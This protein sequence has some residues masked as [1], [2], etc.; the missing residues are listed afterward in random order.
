MR[1][2]FFVWSG[3]RTGNLRK[4]RWSQPGKIKSEGK[5]KDSTED[6][7]NKQEARARTLCKVQYSSP[8]PSCEKSLHVTLFNRGGRRRMWVLL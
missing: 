3:S 5:G 8:H 2:V 6:C 1:K 7:V 4:V